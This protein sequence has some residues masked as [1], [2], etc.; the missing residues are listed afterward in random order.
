MT[1]EV[2]QLAW[3]RLFDSVD[4]GTY[5]SLDGA[6]AFMY[7]P[8]R[9]AFMSDPTVLSEITRARRHALPFMLLGSMGTG[10]NV[11]LEL[12]ASPPGK[13]ARMCIDENVDGHTE[14][15]MLE[16]FFGPGGIVDVHQNESVLLHFDLLQNAVEWPLFCD[17]LH[18][19]ARTH[20]LYRTDGQR[21]S[22]MDIR[23]VGG[24]TTELAPLIQ[25]RPESSFGYLYNY[26]A[27]NQ[28][29]RTYDLV[30]RTG[31]MSTLLGEII[32]AQCIMGRATTAEA[33]RVE[34]ISSRTLHVLENHTWAGQFNELAALVQEALNTGSW[35]TAV[36]KSIQCKLYII[37][38][39]GHERQAR[40]LNR[41]LRAAQFPTFFSPESMRAGNWWNQIQAELDKTDYVILCLTRDVLDPHFE[42]VSVEEARRVIKRAERM[43]RD[44]FIIPV[45]LERDLRPE[46]VPMP[47]HGLVDWIDYI[48]K[49]QWY[50]V[51]TTTGEGLQNLIME[52]QAQCADLRR[53][54]LPGT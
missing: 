6:T 19:L 25:Q 39:S 50:W 33:E 17:K 47:Q 2:V 38:S 28:L 36:A 10:K 43:N 26:L 8:T 37:W 1:Q 40:E 5:E 41:M 31:R 23:V 20:T 54:S 14:G 16:K 32:A 45:V 18:E 44:T 30:N 46:N 12:V 22:G 34:Q 21:F 27:R 49:Q 52:L 15:E 24:A 3:R 13:P 51:D 53:S 7:S 42:G 29:A 4:T 9:K 48:K 35:E 11:F